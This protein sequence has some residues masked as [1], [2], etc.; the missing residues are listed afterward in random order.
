MCKQITVYPSSRAVLGD[1]KYGAQTPATTQGIME[2]NYANTGRMSMTPWRR[3]S[4]EGETTGMATH[5]WLPGSTTGGG[6]GARQ[7]VFSLG[8]DVLL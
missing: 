1:K 2:S 7:N 3:H 4:R 8:V 5:H 6:G